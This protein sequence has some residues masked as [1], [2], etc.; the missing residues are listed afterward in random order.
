MT[1][2]TANTTTGIV[3]NATNTASY[4]NPIVINAGVTITRNV[5]GPADAFAAYAGF[6]TV[7]NKGTISSVNPNAGVY[8]LDGGT[9]TN[10]TSASIS[11]AFG[12]EIS[13][14][15]AAVVNNGSIAG[16][17]RK[18]AGV[19]LER[20]GYI[21]NRVGASIRGAVDGVHIQYYA[22]TVING[23]TIAGTS[24]TYSS[25]GAYLDF[26]GKVSNKTAGLVRGDTGIKISGHVGTVVNNGKI[27]GTAGYGI[28][29]EAGGRV[30]NTVGAL[31]HGQRSGLRSPAATGR[32][33][34]PAWYWRL[35]RYVARLVV[36]SPTRP[37][38]RLAVSG[39]TAASERW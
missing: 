36:W 38:R 29:L 31:D 16:N 1:T 37:R 25:F 28:D 10:T 4:T 17:A 27:T 6:W 5:A 14:S 19:W 9:V 13:F 33:S 26:G 34:T 23:G 24:A 11:G 30:T 12:V 32:L 2:I 39:F 22:G 20:G 15:S 18:G 7:D 3:I 35:R 21:G 8:L